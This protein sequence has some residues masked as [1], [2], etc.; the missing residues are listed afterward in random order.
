M[1]T[2]KW[3]IINVTD[4]GQHGLDAVRYTQTDFTRG[5][6]RLMFVTVLLSVLDD[7]LMAGA[8]CANF[9]QRN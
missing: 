8:R 2:Q 5:Q 9:T 4:G 7:D 1:A 3:H 6:N